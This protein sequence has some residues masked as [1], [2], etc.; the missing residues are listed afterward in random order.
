MDRNIGFTIRK[1]SLL[2]QTLGMMT[3][4]W[5][6]RGARVDTATYRKLQRYRGKRVGNILELYVENA[7][8][9]GCG[10]LV[11]NYALPCGRTERKGA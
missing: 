1:T 10:K 5:D 4:F 8:L 7:M 6:V 2:Y 11:E 9:N 3:V